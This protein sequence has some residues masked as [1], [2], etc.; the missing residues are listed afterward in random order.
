MSKEFT[1]PELQEMSINIRNVDINEIFKSDGLVLSR[2]IA[3]ILSATKT[4]KIV[5]SLFIQIPE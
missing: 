1:D 2:K 4:M 5:F 3:S